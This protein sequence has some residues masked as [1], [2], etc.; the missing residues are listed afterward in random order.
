MILRF[1]SFAVLLKEVEN[2]SFP[3][4]RGLPSSPVRGL[5]RCVTCAAPVV[6][7]RCRCA[8]AVHGARNGVARS[9]PPLA[10]GYAPRESQAQGDQQA[11][12]PHR[13]AQ[14]DIV[15]HDLTLTRR[16]TARCAH[17]IA[18]AR[19][20]SV[21]LPSYPTCGPARTRNTETA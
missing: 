6:V 1:G 20:R 8:L 10:L 5:I 21:P 11:G 7:C 14:N 15:M 9:E 19:A 4:W 17:A 13:Q 3:R 18:G 2:H 16:R 12:K